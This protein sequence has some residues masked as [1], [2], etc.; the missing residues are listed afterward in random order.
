M[1]S[2][3]G[4]QWVIRTAFAVGVITVVTSG[5]AVAQQGSPSS[6]Q[7]LAEV[8][9]SWEKRQLATKSV[10]VTWVHKDTTPKGAIDLLFPDLMERQ[11]VKSSGQPRPPRDVTSEGKGVLL[12][13]D[14][15]G[16]LS[17]DEF[18]WDEQK[19]GF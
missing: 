3:T 15:K 19:A 5:N 16:R 17:L 12:L 2:D 4:T 11:R 18:I 9:A 14:K 1:S 10:R 6:D 8:R 13:E 7:L